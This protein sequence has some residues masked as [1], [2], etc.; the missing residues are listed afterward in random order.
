MISQWLTWLNCLLVGLIA[1]FV[2]AAGALWLK[3]PSEIACA[4]PIA[5]QCRLPK[6]AFAQ[7]LEAYKTM[8]EPILVLQN[9]PPSIQLPDLRQQIVYY[10]KNG[11]PDARV[12]GILLHF[13]FTGNKAITSIA[14]GEKLYLLYDKKNTPSRYTFSPNN[15]ETS[16]WIEAHP[17]DNEVAVK[18][19]MKNEKGELVAEPDTHAQ[20]KL[21][22]KEFMR[23]SGASWEIGG[24]RVDGTLLAR[25][26]A[27]WFGPDR[28][29]EK[30][31]GKEYESIVGKH[32][33]DFGE[34]D[35][36][37][38]VF[39]GVGDCF[40]WDGKRWKAAQPGEES[41]KHPLLS[42]KKADERLMMLELWD[43]EGKGKVSL[44]LLKST[45][46][47][48]VQNPQ[49]IQQ[50]FKFVGARTRT[51]C[52]FEINRERMTIRPGDWLLLTPKGWKKLNTATEIDEYVKRKV[53][54]TLFV[55]EGLLRKDERQ[56]MA[57]ILYSPSRNESQDI[58][59]ALQPARAAK[60]K[61][62]VIESSDDDDEDDDDDDL[63]Y[64]PVPVPNN[65]IKDQYPKH[66]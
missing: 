22:E 1:C 17:V 63:Y 46:P 5:K 57:G 10:G 3:R 47:W 39:G 45:E 32:R 24:F 29:L 13:S 50:M 35:E 38:S 44:N 42:I 8:G 21:P 33:I 16:L 60:E 52:V 62:E 27:R 31:G 9:A 18:A 54:G 41:L 7:P 53:T 23:Y 64:P 48:L 30:H 11:R 6:N 65:L 66:K 37:Y 28:F 59:L 49:A 14:P 2:L 51:Q 26:R 56:M 43:V 61:K 19:W 36:I 55:F 40:I 12:A 34:N 20:F 58:E 4:N 15:A 25:Q